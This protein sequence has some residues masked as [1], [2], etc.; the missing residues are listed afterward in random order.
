MSIRKRFSEKDLPARS[1]GHG[2]R[3]TSSPS[4]GCA[5]RCNG[6]SVASPS[7]A[8]RTPSVT[9]GSTPSRRANQ[10]LVWLVALAAWI[11]G[12]AGRGRLNY[13]RRMELTERWITDTW[14]ALVAAAD[15]SHGDGPFLCEC[16]SPHCTEPLQLAP[17]ELASLHAE[18]DLFAIVPG[19]E[20]PD[21]ETV[22]RFGR[23]LR[24][25]PQAHGKARQ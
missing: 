17:D 12:G 3:S 9:A 19:H 21:L 8:R 7:A 15:V 24:D 2:A 13:S 1:N 5:N 14:V 10:C 25:R 16:A 6:S 23:P 20:V 18:P 22:V 4:S 11:D